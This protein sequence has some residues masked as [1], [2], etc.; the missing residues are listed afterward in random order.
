MDVI[1]NLPAKNVILKRLIIDIGNTLDKVAVFDNDKTVFIDKVKNLD[2]VVLQNIFSAF[3]GIESSVISAVKSY[4]PEIDK[5][6]EQ[7]CFLLKITG[8]V[9]LPFRNLYKTPETLG[10]DRI[11]LATAGVKKFPGKNVLI[12]DA[13]TTIT[14]D[15]VNASAEYLG[16]G[17]SPGI[18]MRFKALNTFTDK[19]PL[20]TVT[21]DTGLIGR[22]TR[23][24]ILSGVLHGICAEVD[25][26]IDKY[27]KQ[28]DNLKVL[29]SG[30]DH[31]Y[32]VKKLKNSIFAAPNL[33]LEG[34][35]EILSFN[36]DF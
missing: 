12:I 16:G 27:K 24:S 29:V 34:L 26:I 4:P 20:I 2:T 7:K 5:F 28:Y 3:P 25:G 18:N 1:V 19:L 21:E 6:I 33:V 32:F 23:T 10:K 35:N 22:D 15:F 36:E 13:G 9:K 14:Y 11:A 17:I 8:K 31:I 30:G